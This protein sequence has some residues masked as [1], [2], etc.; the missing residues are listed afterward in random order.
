MLN[1]LSARR[2]GRKDLYKLW[3]EGKGKISARVCS[4]SFK[5][6]LSLASDVTF[7]Y[8][9]QMSRCISTFRRRTENAIRNTKAF[10]HEK[11]MI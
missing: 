2:E 9:A 7:L 4:I 5:F 3:G 10:G 1:V 8:F 11:D 6:T